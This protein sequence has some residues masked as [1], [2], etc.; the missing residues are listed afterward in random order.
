M[1]ATMS[2]KFSL[3]GVDTVE[4]YEPIRLGEYNKILLSGIN[5]AVCQP[6]TYGEY[7]K[8]ISGVDTAV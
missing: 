4:R 2:R 3:S 8:I 7:N 5:T 6:V 1:P